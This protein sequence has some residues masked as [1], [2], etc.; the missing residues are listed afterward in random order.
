MTSVQLKKSTPTSA[1]IAAAASIAVSKSFNT[2]LFVSSSV[3][4][5]LYELYSDLE[6]IAG[7]CGF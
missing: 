6:R 4:L 7:I 1:S 5:Q 2:C 3:S